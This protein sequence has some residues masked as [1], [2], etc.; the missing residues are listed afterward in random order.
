M[1]TN[2]MPEPDRE[3]EPLGEREEPAQ[4]PLL[5]A[6]DLILMLNERTEH[7]PA[8]LEFVN[9]LAFHFKAGR[10][11]L[12]WW[13]GDVLKLIATSHT[14]RLESRMTAVRD[15]EKTM[16]ECADQADLI[17]WPPL[18][19]DLTI[20]REHERFASQHSANY[21]LS[22]P[23]IVDDE[24]KGVVTLQR[25][26]Q[27]FREAE[28]EALELIADLSARRLDDLEQRGR[29]WWNNSQ[30]RI[31]QWL[32]DFL[33]PEHTW[34]KAGSILG[35]LVMAFLLFWP[36]PHRIKGDFTLMTEA[37]INLP[38]PYDGFLESV[39]ASPG[40]EVSEGAK[41]LSLNT[42]E[43]KLKEAEALANVRRFQS[44]AQMAQGTGALSDFHV[45]TAQQSE[46]MAKL[47]LI[48]S[49]LQRASIT[50]PFDGIITEGK[51]K[52]QLGGPVKKGDILMKMTRMEDL[53]FEIEVPERD[54]QEVKEGADVLL[55]FTSRPDI[56]F[57]GVV[58]IIEP[59]AVPVEKD[60]VFIIRCS[61][62]GEIED[63]WRPGMSG[64]ARI[65]AGTASPLYLLTHRL[66]DYIRLKLWL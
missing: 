25:E 21:L 27:R 38:A 35:A 8:I 46:T 24:V 5:V 42:A 41:L 15:L 16:L 22:V 55:T 50:A 59:A 47:S 36:L 29:H 10:V 39:E 33:G 57:P 9:E 58:D 44:Q 19:E 6:L 34:W 49:N 63:W 14:H 26:G 53:Y 65:D 61:R 31:R 51:L 7:Q 2:P 4:G 17:Y 13:R 40:D 60:S 62:D 28:G 56:R 3:A 32:A 12:G 11:S 43:L 52:E 66:I 1:E 23:L 64:V 20:T 54:I 37:L 18:P 30:N 45:A 48:R